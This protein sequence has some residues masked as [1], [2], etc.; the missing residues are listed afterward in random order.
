MMSSSLAASLVAQG[1]T[2][3]DIGERGEKRLAQK[4][5]DLKNETLCREFFE[6]MHN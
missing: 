1:G 5:F 2:V 4:L 6:R 3:G